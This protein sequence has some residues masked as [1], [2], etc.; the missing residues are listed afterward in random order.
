MAR[1]EYDPVGPPIGRGG[2]SLLVWV[3]IFVHTSSYDWSQP[4]G[5][6]VWTTTGGLLAGSWLAWSGKNRSGKRPGVARAGLLLNLGGLLCV[7]LPV[8]VY[9]LV[10]WLSS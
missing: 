5:I 1:S 9:Y 4:L 3:A 7:V 2:L 10:F 6:L 8:L